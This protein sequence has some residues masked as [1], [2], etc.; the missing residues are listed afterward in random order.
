MEQNV[1]IPV[2]GGSGAGGGLA[3]FL[4]GQHFSTT[5]EQIVDNPAPWQG[6]GGGLQGLHRGQSS[7]AF[8]EQ[9]AESPDPGGGLQRLLRF[10]LDTLVKG[11]FALFCRSKKVRRSPARWMKNTSGRQLI[12][13]GGS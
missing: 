6:V 10:L 9:I 7:T 12:H 8:L 13:A 1:D 2:V 3:C 11:F 4:P 5:A